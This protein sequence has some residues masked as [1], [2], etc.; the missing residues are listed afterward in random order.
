MSTFI[1]QRKFGKK[2]IL[3]GAAVAACLALLVAITASAYSASTASSSGFAIAAAVDPQDPFQW[4]LSEPGMPK[5]AVFPHQ[6]AQRRRPWL[7]VA[8]ARDQS[9]LG[10]SIR[11][12][13]LDVQPPQRS[14]HTA[15]PRRRISRAAECHGGYVY[16]GTRRWGINLNWSSTPK[17]EWKVSKSGTL[18][19]LRNE[20]IRDFVVYGRRLIGGNLCWLQDVTLRVCVP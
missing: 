2:G 4:D 6:Q 11:T 16:Y 12:R 18:F 19:P 8:P 5:V 20:V 17:Y 9:R 10:Q 1:I 3:S 14:R 15:H 13:K 7:P